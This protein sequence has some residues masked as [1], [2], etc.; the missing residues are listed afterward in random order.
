MTAVTDPAPFLSTI[1]ASSAGMVAIVGG[2][3]VARFVTL[4]SEQEGAQHLLDDAEARLVIARRRAKEADQRLY[5]WDVVH[6]FEPEVIQAIGSGTQDIAKL[7]DIG[8]Y[9]SLSDEQLASEVSVIA[10]EFDLARRTL[11][12]LIPPEQRNSDDYVKWEEF[13]RTVELPEIK[14]EDVW[15]SVYG[16]LFYTPRPTSRPLLGNISLPRSVL[17]PTVPEYVTQRARRRDGLR[18]NVERTRQQ[19][20]DIEGEVVRLR[21]SREAIV[22]PKGLGWGLLVLAVF[23]IVGVIIPVWLMSRAPKRLTAHLGEIVFWLFLSG[24]L[25]LLGYMGTLA[26]RLSGWRWSSVKRDEADRTT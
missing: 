25:A 13:S 18:A 6:F 23:T 16:G 17:V 5:D 11:E 26:L 19:V 2:L 15:K 20:E 9:T 21:R 10:A 14:W 3:L 1:A 24:L 12:D 7:R 4:I 22:R 8:G